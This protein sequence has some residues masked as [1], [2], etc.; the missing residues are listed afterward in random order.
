M[1]IWKHKYTEKTFS[2]LLLF[3][4]NLPGKFIVVHITELTVANREG[5]KPWVG[6]NWG[7]FLLN[8]VLGSIPVVFQYRGRKRALPNSNGSSARCL[9]VVLAFFMRG[10]QEEWGNSQGT[11]AEL[12]EQDMGPGSWREGKG[13]KSFDVTHMVMPCTTQTLPPSNCPVASLPLTMAVT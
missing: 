13:S 7:G 5:G 2:F 11:T 9:L 4:R 8:R 10:G 3:A 12:R 1:P 6:R